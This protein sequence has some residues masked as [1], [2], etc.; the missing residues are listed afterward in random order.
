MGMQVG[1]K[2]NQFVSLLEPLK[3]L[4]NKTW[5]TGWENN[6]VPGITEQTKAKGSSDMVVLPINYTAQEFILYNKAMF[7]EAGITQ[8]P[9]TYDELK[10]DVALLKQKGVDIPLVFGAKDGWHD[11]DMF[12]YLSNQFGPGKIYDAEQGKLAWTDKV[13]VDTMKAWKQMIDDGVIQKGAVGLSTYPD[14]RDQYFVF[15][16]VGHVPYWNLARCSRSRNERY[17]D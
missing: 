3:P 16:Q 13:F 8:V 15:T 6:F 17:Q 4:A 2:L 5:G 14:A 9:K 12:I 11:A 10:K 7:D 1:G